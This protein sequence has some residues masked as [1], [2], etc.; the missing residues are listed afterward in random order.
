MVTT[1]LE[2][3]KTSPKLRTLG[4][5]LTLSLVEDNVFWKP[6]RLCVPSLRLLNTTQHHGG[7]N[8]NALAKTR[9]LISVRFLLF[10]EVYNGGSVTAVAMVR[11]APSLLLMWIRPT[12]CCLQM[13]DVDRAPSASNG[14]MAMLLL[15]ND[16]ECIF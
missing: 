4:A 6:S 5:T 2:A 9:F 13:P 10:S 7:G 15:Q 16:T 12:K 3:Q 1:L 14:R 8:G 11:T